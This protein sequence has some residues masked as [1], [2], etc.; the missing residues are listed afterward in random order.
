[1]CDVEIQV[2]LENL[3]LLVCLQQIHDIIVLRLYFQLGMVKHIKNTFT[4][5]WQTE[6]Q[7]INIE[8]INQFPIQL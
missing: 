2:I 7:S 6:V 8:T 3:G 4:T 1:M 5:P